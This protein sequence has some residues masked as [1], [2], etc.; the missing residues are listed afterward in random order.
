MSAKD[1]IKKSVLE[2]D[3][4]KNSFTPD[5]I[6]QMVIALGVALLMGLAICFI[7]NRFF[8]GVV[9]NRSFA[10]TLVGMTV[11]T[12]MVTL[13]I[14][15]NV[16]LSLGMVGAL[17]IVRYRTAVKDPMDLLYLFW[18]IT[19]GIAVGASMFAL[20]LIAAIAMILVLLI[21]SRRSSKG[22]VYIVLLH[23]TGD[24][25]GDN[26]VRAMGNTRFR[27]KSKTLRGENAEMAMEVF[28]K[29]RNMVFLEKLRAVEGVDDVTLIQ[30]DGE[31][32]D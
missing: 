13:A 7:Y 10:V 6:L 32:H 28:C 26:I 25:V 15:T 17:S 1:V 5:K 20:V 8:R 23:Y 12:C 11:L 14:S 30:Y 19:T 31:Y 27:V 9:Y 2:L 18:A 29:T 21:F 3:M 24:L 4:F 16:V 22:Q